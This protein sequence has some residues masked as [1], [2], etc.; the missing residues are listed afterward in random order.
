MTQN[1]SEDN[2]LLLFIN[3]DLKSNIFFGNIKE[4]AQIREAFEAQNLDDE[5]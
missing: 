5:R 4:L 2:V 1:C 3:K